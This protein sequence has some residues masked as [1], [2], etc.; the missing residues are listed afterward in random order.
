MSP[1]RIYY[2]DVIRIRLS[3][4]DLNGTSFAYSPV[5]EMTSSLWMLASG[6]VPPIHQAWYDEIRPKLGRLDWPVLRA[7]APYRHEL[8]VFLFPPTNG[9]QTTADKQL[10]TVADV[11]HDLMRS[12][13]ECTWNGG[14]M[15]DAARSLIAAGHAGPRR[16]AEALWDY[17]AVALEPHWARIRAVMDDDVG[18][19]SAAM[20]DAGMSGVLAGLDPKFRF[21]GET[22]LIDKPEDGTVSLNGAGLRLIPSVFVDRG[23]VYAGPLPGRVDNTRDVEQEPSVAYPSRRLIGVWQSDAECDEVSALAALI[24]RS[25]A[26]MLLRLGLPRATSGLAQ[27]LG[28]SQ[29]AANQHLTLLRRSGLL[30]S[31]RSGRFVLYQR[32]AMADELIAG[33]PTELAARRTRGD[34]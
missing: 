20:V 30:S 31:R 12:E 25:R 15:P 24:G 19:R 4:A 17:W 14:P 32:T 16:V 18:Y 11:P 5:A 3:V 27:E 22:I 34:A 6:A 28:L 21:E 23:P 1:G 33:A 8:P 29:A 13:L 7:V 2:L 10:G 26:A 9:V